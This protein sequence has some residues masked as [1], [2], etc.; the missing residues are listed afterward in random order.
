MAVQ[1]VS[2][3][4]VLRN[5][6]VKSVVGTVR[7]KVT[8]ARIRSAGGSDGLGDLDLACRKATSHEDVIPKEKHV[9]TLKQA[10]GSAGGF[11]TGEVNHVIHKLQKRLHHNH[12]WRVS[13]KALIVFHRLLAEVDTSFQNELLSY[14]E[15]TGHRRLLLLDTYLDANTNDTWDYS[16]WIRAYSTYLDSR[17][18]V[19]R[20][21]GIDVSDY[22]AEALPQLLQSMPACDLIGAV[23]VLL[24]D[25]A[26]LLAAVPEGIA[27]KH[28]ICTAAGVLVAKEAGAVE[29]ALQEGLIA[30]AE[31]CGELS[32]ADAAAAKELYRR[33]MELHDEAINHKAKVESI[34]A[35]SR[36]AKLAQPVPPPAEGQR[37]LEER[38]AETNASKPTNRRRSSGGGT[39]S[40]AVLKPKAAVTHGEKPTHRPSATIEVKAVS[41]CAV[42]DLLSDLND[43]A[44][45]PPPPA[46]KVPTVKPAPHDPFGLDLLDAYSVTD[47]PAPLASQHWSQPQG[48]AGLTIDP[49]FSSVASSDVSQSP[50]SAATAMSFPST[51]STPTSMMSFDTATPVKKQQHQ[52]QASLMGNGVYSPSP[53]AIQNGLPFQG[54]PFGSPPPLRGPS[55]PAYGSMAAPQSMAASVPVNALTTAGLSPTCGMPTSDLAKNSVAD[56]FAEL[57]GLTPQK[58]HQPRMR[59]LRC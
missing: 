2:V 58:A 48:N 15:K 21:L 5:E 22:Q 39:Y 20:H 18:A 11:G 25:R 37:L 8:A 49:F 50:F 3:G 9:I 56:P 51:A 24:R 59:T 46:E 6:G 55:Q 47:D 43:V 17:V 10:S 41:A 12:G 52:H 44:A 38:V 7:D 54:N 23:E 45:V 4:S 27:A 34:P 1:S 13:T 33:A 32:A 14:T 16:C 36:A 40:P 29:R 28:H 53:A 19:Y 30:I 42:S 35:L 31:R 57:T 26:A